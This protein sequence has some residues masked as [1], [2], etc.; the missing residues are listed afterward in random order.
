VTWIVVADGQRARILVRRRE[1]PGLETIRALESAHAHR[2]SAELGSS[3]P[4]RTQ[5]SV[6]A[7]RHA[8]EP[9][10]DLHGRDKGEFAAAVAAL[11]DDAATRHEFDS[12]VVV[13]LP[14]TAAAIRRAMRDETVRKIERQVA[15]DLTKIAD[16]EIASHL[17]EPAA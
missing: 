5:E 16:D 6:G 13:A 17:A 14:R 12:L 3:A 10:L 1:R 4:G 2:K 9:K 8:I 11:L 15:R 7:A